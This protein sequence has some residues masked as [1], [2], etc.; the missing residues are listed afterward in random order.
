MPCRKRISGVNADVGEAAYIPALQ[1]LRY[2]MCIVL[3]QSSF[4]NPVV[5]NMAPA[6]V[7]VVTSFNTADLT[8]FVIDVLCLPEGT[9]QQLL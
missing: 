5:T 2:G 7:V 4:R 9:K 6:L 1:Q 8:L 3:V